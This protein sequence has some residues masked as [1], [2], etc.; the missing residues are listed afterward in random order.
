MGSSMTTTDDYKAF[1]EW[2]IRTGCWE[3]CGL[4]GGEIQDKALEFGIIEKVDYDPAV[5]GPNNVGAEP[6]ASWFVF[7][8]PARDR[9]QGGEGWRL[10]RWSIPAAHDR[11]QG[12]EG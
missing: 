3:G 2:V 8:L 9:P 4:N 12:G 10:C 7:V 1:A 5:H 11:P 6:G